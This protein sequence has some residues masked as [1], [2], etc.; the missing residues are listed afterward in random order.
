MS[1]R[2][3]AFGSQ[4]AV[5]A[6]AAGSFSSEWIR[7]TRDVISPRVASSFGSPPIPALTHARYAL[8]HPSGRWVAGAHASNFL[9]WILVVPGGPALQ[10]C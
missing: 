8:F 2:R 3:G 9:P 4:A 1:S 10:R 6:A 7:P 5:P